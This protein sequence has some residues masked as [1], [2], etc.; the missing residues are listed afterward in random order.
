MVFMTHMSNY[1]TGQLAQYEFEGVTKAID[2][3]TNLKMLAPH[4]IDVAREYFQLYPDEVSPL[5][6]VRSALLSEDLL[7]F[8][9]YFKII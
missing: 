1:A 6:S 2:T 4:P 7:K 8:H 9:F 3:W 5:W